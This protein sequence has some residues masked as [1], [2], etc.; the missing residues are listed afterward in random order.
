MTAFGV[1]GLQ[2]RHYGTSKTYCMMLPTDIDQAHAHTA[3]VHVKTQTI[4]ADSAITAGEKTLSPDDGDCTRR[5]KWEKKP[6]MTI[7]MAKS[8]NEH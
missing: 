4:N 6:F 3:N 1:E 7:V 8:M 2:N 5:R